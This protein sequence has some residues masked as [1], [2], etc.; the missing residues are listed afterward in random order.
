MPDFDLSGRVALVTGGNGGI[1]RGMAIGLAE[2]GAD[3][4]IAARNQDKTAVVVAEIEALGRRAIAV[5]CDVT[6]EA[7]LHTSVARTVEELGSLDILV[8]NAGIGG[9]GAYPQEIEAEDWDRILGTNL[10]SPMLMCKAAHDA[11]KATGHGSII[12]VSSI[13]ALMGSI[14]GAQ[15]TASKAGLVNL[16]KSLAISYARDSIRVNAVLPGFVATDFIEK[17]IENQ[18]AYTY[19]LGR[20]PQRRFAEP[21]E[22][23]GV[24][25]FLA[26]DA[27][28]FITG[29]ALV[30]DGGYTA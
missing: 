26:S 17:L 11:L 20:T 18:Q 25:A 28:S 1:G 22:F 30:V 7:D 23:G 9:G 5:R 27:S 29:H 10:K 15:Y 24:A 12:N 6:V 8:N 13:K 19:E 16:T 14:R 21:E 4:A 2:A 3:V